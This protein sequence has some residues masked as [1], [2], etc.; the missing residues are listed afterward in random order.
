MLEVEEK[1]QTVIYLVTE[2][3]MPLV[4]VLSDLDM[5][6]AAKYG[7]YRPGMQI[8]LSRSDTGPAASS[9]GAMQERVHCD[10][11]LPHSSC[12]LVSQQRLWPGEPFGHTLLS[13]AAISRPCLVGVSHL[14]LSAGHV[15]RCTAMCACA[16]L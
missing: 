6:T 7:Q 3:V 8:G 16:L 5:S 2:P 1:G 14:H 13:D 15:H 9:S 11:I 4:Q 12:C 10:G